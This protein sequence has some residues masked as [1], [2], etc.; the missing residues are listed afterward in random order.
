MNCRSCGAGN[1]NGRFC[2]NCG[3]PL[4]NT[5]EKTESAPGRTDSASQPVPPLINTVPPG[6][7]GSR[8]VFPDRRTEPVTVPET[9]ETQNPPQMQTEGPERPAPAERNIKK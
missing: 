4:G 6:I 5:G 8:I 1:Q 9:P 3:T 7:Y 2:T